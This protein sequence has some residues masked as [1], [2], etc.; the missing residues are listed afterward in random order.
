MRRP[1]PWHPDGWLRGTVIEAG[2]R[3]PLDGVRVRLARLGRHWD[4]V[5]DQGLFR[6]P[7]LAPGTYALT[8]D[9]DSHGRLRTEYVIAPVG[10]PQAG[11]SLQLDALGHLSGQVVDRLGRP[12]AQAK[13][14][15][16]DVT[17]RRSRS[18][19]R[20]HFELRG[21]PPGE[22]TLRASHPQAGIAQAST[23]YRVRAGEVRPGAVIRLPEVVPDDPVP[24]GAPEEPNRKEPTA[25]DDPG[26][27]RLFSLPA[28]VLEYRNG[29]FITSAGTDGGPLRSGDTIT[30]INDESVF[31]VAQARSMLRGPRGSRVRV[32][33]RRGGRA[34]T[35]RLRR[36]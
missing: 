17:H 21:L 30:A 13:V 7:P 5:S 29:V 24:A 20:G 18:D 33:V 28:V 12:V 2:S 8:T 14:S 26:R 19:A 34:L 10:R 9:T 3:Q 6:F 23:T 1:W 11:L 31:S 22:V 27:P 35:L 25:A 4:S 36:P 15:A 32:R 16:V